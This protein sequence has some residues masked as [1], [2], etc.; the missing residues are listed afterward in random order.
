MGGWDGPGDRYIAKIQLGWSRA[1]G[2]GRTAVLIALLLMAVVAPLLFLVAAIAAQ[3]LEERH[4]RSLQRRSK[5]D[6]DNKS[7]EKLCDD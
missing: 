7:P 2:I 6:N 5:P 3:H 4:L 1:W